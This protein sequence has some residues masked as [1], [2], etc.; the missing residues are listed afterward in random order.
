MDGAKPARLNLALYR[1]CEGALQLGGSFALFQLAIDK[2]K[3]FAAASVQANQSANMWVLGVLITLALL[4]GF[5]GFIATME[6]FVQTYSIMLRGPLERSR[7]R[8]TKSDAQ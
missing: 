4:A 5:A 2:Q 8:P 6:G 1:F 7:R 3:S